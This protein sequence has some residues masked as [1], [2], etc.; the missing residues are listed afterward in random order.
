MSS[1][2]NTIKSKGNNNQTI[3]IYESDIYVYVDDYLDTLKDRDDIYNNGSLFT[4]MCKYI[5]KHVFKNNKPDYD[6]IG[7]LDNIWDVY[8]TLC[9]QYGKRPSLLNFS[10]FTGID[11][12]TFT[13][14][15]S[16]QYR[17]NGQG[18][19]SIHSRTVRKWQ[20]ECESSL[21]DGA[22]EKNS[23]GCIFALKANYGWTEQPQRI[24][25]VGNNTPQLTE[26]EIAQIADSGPQ[27]ADIEP[28]F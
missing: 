12:T 13:T 8:T 23:I 6:N 20:K 4:G 25:I 1:G 18:T 24:E 28:D 26:T 11:N 21:A 2:Y 5:Y 14:W 19:Q 9:Y 10:L 15:A 27:D 17:S 3:E 7:L 22:T 16:G